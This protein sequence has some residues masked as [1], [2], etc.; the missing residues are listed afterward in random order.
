M[1][2]IFLSLMALLMFSVTPTLADTETNYIK[3]ILEVGYEYS[4]AGFVSA[5]SYGDST[6]VENFLKSGYNPNMKIA[7]VPVV[8]YATTNEKEKTLDV[9]LSNGADVNTTFG[10]V[11]LLTRAIELKNMKLVNVL[12]KH[13]VDVNKATFG[14]TP[15]NFALLNKNVEIAKALINAGAKVDKTSLK[16]SKRTKDTVFIEHL[17]SLYNAENKIVK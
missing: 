1:K 7:K 8:F 11:T 4:V 13:H 5:V 17:Y 14:L 3:S 16:Y 2:K 6:T 15:L 9:L 10:N 12:L